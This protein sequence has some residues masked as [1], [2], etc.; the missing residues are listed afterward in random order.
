[1]VSSSFINWLRVVIRFEITRIIRPKN[2]HLNIHTFR[3]FTDTFL[4]SSRLFTRFEAKHVSAAGRADKN[5]PTI[6]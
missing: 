6:G 5:R 1:M 4:W 3:M 2:M